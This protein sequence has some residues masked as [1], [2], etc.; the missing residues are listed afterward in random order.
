LK[1]NTGFQGNRGFGLNRREMNDFI[2]TNDDAFFPVNGISKDMNE[3]IVR[4]SDKYYLIQDGKMINLKLGSC[5]ID[6]NEPE[7]KIYGTSP[8]DFWTSHETTDEVKAI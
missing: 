2:D 6:Q 4:C 1:I 7:E 8:I 3:M 5:V